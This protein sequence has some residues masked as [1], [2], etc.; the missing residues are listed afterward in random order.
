MINSALWLN[1][2]DSTKGNGLSIEFFITSLIVVLMPGAGSIYTISTGLFRGWRSSI[3]AA[4]GCTAGII[5][6]LLFSILVL[7]SVYEYSTATFQVIKYI[8]AVYLLYLAYSMWRESGVS[9]FLEN[10]DQ[11]KDKLK[12]I[13]NAIFI[14]LFN[15]KLSIFFLAFLPLFVSLE[16]E[17]PV[18][19]FIFLS[20]IFMLMTLIVFII[21]GLFA[22][23][24]SKYFRKSGVQY[25]WTQRAF[26]IIFVILGAKLLIMEI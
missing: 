24:V 12:I 11:K 9:E 3:V 16:S 5:P 22:H 2:Q 25:I 6:H 13:L 7:S 23:N 10:F 14:N 26:A 15:P 20:I 4:F 21:Y 19:Q 1:F 17:F 8:G 18:G